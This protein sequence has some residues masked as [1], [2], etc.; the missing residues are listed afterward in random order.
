MNLLSARA[1]ADSREPDPP[2]RLLRDKKSSLIPTW[3]PSWVPPSG[4]VVCD[5]LT[6]LS[7]GESEE[8]FVGV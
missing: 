8:L 1:M 5:H 7:A 3:A 2:N 4:S 6:V